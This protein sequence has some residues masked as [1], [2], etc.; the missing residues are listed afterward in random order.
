LAGWDGALLHACE[1]LAA[2]RRS[3]ELEPTERFVERLR[4][5]PLLVA[6][7]AGRFLGPWRLANLERFF[8]E[9]AR[10]LEE[11]RGDDA[12]VLRALRREDAADADWDEGRPARPG[13]DAVQVM[14]I[15]GAKGLQFEHVYLLQLHKQPP[16][17]EAE[18]FRAGVGPLAGEW[19]LGVD[20]RPVASTLGFDLVKAARESVERHERVRTLYVAMTRAK[21]RLVVSGHWSQEAAQIGRASG[22][23]G[24]QV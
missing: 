10:M 7:E 19:C 9:L 4:A 14:S 8:R 24:G 16:R 21:R 11:S 12:A 2:L 17:D 22:R 5:L 6:G 18:P 20:G 3:F 13:D 1:V 15:H 23:E